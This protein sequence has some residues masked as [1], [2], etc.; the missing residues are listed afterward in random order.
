MNVYTVTKFSLHLSFTVHYFYT[1]ISNFMAFL[2]MKIVLNCFL[3]AYFLHLF[4]FIEEFSQ[5]EIAVAV[6]GL[7][8]EH[9]GSVNRRGHYRL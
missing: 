4:F 7:L 9:R 3:C 1:K 8:R 5:L 2:S 6:G